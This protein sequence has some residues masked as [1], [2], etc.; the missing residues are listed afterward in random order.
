VFHGIPGHFLTVHI[1][2]ARSPL[3]QARSIGR[4]V[5]GDDVF[6][7]LQFGALPRRALEVKQVVEEQSAVEWKFV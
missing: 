7:G 5:E 4:E 1:E 6:A 3:A 2:H